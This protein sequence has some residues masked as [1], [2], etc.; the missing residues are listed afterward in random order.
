MSAI[1]YETINLFN[2]ENNILPYRYIGSDQHN[3]P[4]YFGSNKKLIS[5]IKKLGKEWFVKNTLVEFH[6]DI[7]N[8]SLRKIESKLQ[9]LKDVAKDPEY[10]NRTNSSH[11]G[12]I[13]TEEEK[14][15]RMSKVIKAHKIWWDNL[16]EQCKK[17][18]KEKSKKAFIDAAASMKGKTYEEIYGKE[19]AEIKKKKHSGKNNGMAKQIMD[20]KTGQIFNTMLEAMNYYGIKKYDTIRNK[21]IE[22]KELR[23]I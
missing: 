20:I 3:K 15:I 10:Y 22:E 4:D 7:D 6:Y 23:F 17:E 16:S 13:E 1:I 9:Q 18:H 19:K 11:C 5:D 8:V 2:K 14:K 12:Y 21:C